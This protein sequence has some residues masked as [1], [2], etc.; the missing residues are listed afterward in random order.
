MT[1]RREQFDDVVEK[2]VRDREYAQATL[3]D[4]LATDIRTN[5][6][7]FDPMRLQ[8]LGPEGVKALLQELDIAPATENDEAQETAPASP[9]DPSIKGWADM[10]RPEPNAWLEAVLFGTG[11][12]LLIVLAAAFATKLPL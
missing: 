7:S 2:A 5:L 11:I 8:A 9:T 10:R 12:S 4:N 6:A 3:V 1:E